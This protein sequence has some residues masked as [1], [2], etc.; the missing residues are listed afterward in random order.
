MA[1]H[2]II[3]QLLNAWLIVRKAI[4]LDSTHHSTTHQSVVHLL[5]Q[6]INHLH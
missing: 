3:M 6:G 1:W 4:V 2:R 5:W